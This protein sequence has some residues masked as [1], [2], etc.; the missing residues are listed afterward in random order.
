VRRGHTS[1]SLDLVSSV[2]N[3]FEMDL[4]IQQPTVIP[5]SPPVIIPG[6]ANLVIPLPALNLDGRDI[7][8]SRDDTPDYR[9]A[10]ATSSINE[11]QTLLVSAP[12]YSPTSPVYTTQV[13]S[14][15]VKVIGSRQRT[16]N[17][18]TT[19]WSL[20]LDFKRKP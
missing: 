5:V 9:T 19:S 1:T 15:M 8:L 7:D 12:S 10:G 13:S 4:M 2:T 6:S 14:N 18:V 16:Q 11:P 17:G 20:L 3:H